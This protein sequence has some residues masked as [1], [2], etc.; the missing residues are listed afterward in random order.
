MIEGRIPPQAI[1]IEEAVLG[2]ILIEKNA[3]MNVVSLLTPEIFYKDAHNKVYKAIQFLNNDNRPVNILTVTQQLKKEGNLEIVGGPYFVSTLTDRIASAS[4][5]E[6][7]VRI[8][9][10]LWMKREIIRVNCG[11]ASIAYD[12]TSDAFDLLGQMQSEISN[13]HERYV[14]STLNTKELVKLSLKSA[15]ERQNNFKKGINNCIGTSVNDINRKIVGAEKGEVI[16]IAARPSMGKTQFA[17]TWAKHASLSGHKPAF[18]SLEMAAKELVD[19]LICNEADIDSLK[20]R[21]GSLNEIEISMINRAAGKVETLNILIEDKCF[22]LNSIKSKSRQA[23]LKEGCNMIIIDYIQLISRPGKND[24]SELEKI[25][26]ELKLLAKELNVPVIVLSQLSRAVEETTTKI[27][28]MNHLRSS[29]AIEQDADII[30]FLW[31]PFVYSI[32]TVNL[33]GTTYEGL[34]ESDI[35]VFIPKFRNGAVGHVHFKCAP[36]MSGFHD[37]NIFGEV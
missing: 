12:E 5:L 32:D 2:A 1:D 7:H 23:V 27:P 15:I 4:D 17:L 21:E 37:V 30:M 11:L 8:L 26:R 6:F 34:D 33:G 29:G 25:S 14:E 35:F 24:N 9:I 36:R 3:L 19:R 20:F 22:D 13:I 18:F 31:R 28:G 10:E 16:I